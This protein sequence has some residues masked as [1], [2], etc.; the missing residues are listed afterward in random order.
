MYGETIS[1]SASGY[2]SFNGYL[3]VPPSGFGPGLVLLYESSVLNRHVRELADLYADEGYTV[4]APDL[5]Y[6][7]RLD[8]NQAMADVKDAVRALKANRAS[9][10][11]IG[12]IGYGRGG[13]L[14]FLAASRRQVEVVVGY[15]G[16]DL[17][18]HLEEAKTIRCPVVSHFGSE[19]ES[20]P[21]EARTAIK[22]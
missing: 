2:A 6:R 22:N 8:L 18:K 1:I 13:L 4:I 19:D 14:A 21:G 7:E 10:G 16:V 9:S 3:S 5:A 12:A 11:K 17:E 15:C 20:V